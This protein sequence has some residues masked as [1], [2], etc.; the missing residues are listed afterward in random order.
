MDGSIILAAVG[1]AAGGAS[2]IIAWAARADSLKAASRAE[3]AEAAALR[4][5]ED[6]ASALKEANDLKTLQYAER[7]ARERKIRRVEIAEH[8]RRWY[9]EDTMRVAT[10]EER[11]AKARAERRELSIRLTATGEPG[12]S[13]LGA[14]MIKA[15]ALVEAG[16]LTSAVEASIKITTLTHAWVQDP[17][18]FESDREDMF[19]ADSL[20]EQITTAVDDLEAALAARTAAS[21]VDE[22]KNPGG[23]ST[24]TR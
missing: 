14:E 23:V 7:L 1:A 3:R 15:S 13:M 20:A 24:E 17:E 2:A 8:F 19:T 16:E 22:S 12:A 6:S 11:S 4:A 21:A 10:G 18:G 9:L 5:W